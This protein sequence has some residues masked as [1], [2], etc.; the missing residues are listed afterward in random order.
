V[1]QETALIFGADRFWQRPFPFWN[2]VTCWEK[3]HKNKKRKKKQTNKI[4]MTE[5]GGRRTE[6]DREKEHKIQIRNVHKWRAKAGFS[7]VAAILACCCLGLGA[8]SLLFSNDGSSALSLSSSPL[9]LPS[10]ST[11]NNNKPSVPSQLEVDNQ[12]RVV[13][14]ILRNKDFQTKTRHSKFCVVGEE[15]NVAKSS[16]E[17]IS[18]GDGTL[19]MGH[20]TSGIE[21]NI[22]R[23]I[24]TILS[25]EGDQEKFMVDVGM[26]S[27]FFGVLS[28]SLGFPIK[29]FDPQPLCHALVEKS[30]EANNFKRDRFETHLMGL[31]D[32]GKGVQSFMEMHVNSCHGG[33]SWPDKWPGAAIKVPMHALADAIGDRR[34][35]L[36]KMDTEGNE[37]SILATGV[38]LFERGQVDYLI[39]ETKPEVWEQRQIDA[40]PIGRLAEIAKSVV[41]LETG[42]VRTN[43]DGAA[44]WKGGNYIFSFVDKPIGKMRPV[45]FRLMTGTDSC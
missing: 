32:G 17:W 16:F 8:K 20:V 28:A 23:K 10:S 19:P 26:N 15:D 39:V 31:G 22:G 11:P 45:S 35:L 27:G 6:D 14:E 5:D 24:A 38:Q 41:L 29:A 13:D 2:F 25:A 12:R 43:G 37:M 4:S 40:A 3:N 21:K 30:R 34:V 42:E 18:Q 36:M 9:S 44:P 7:M 33:Y 1:R